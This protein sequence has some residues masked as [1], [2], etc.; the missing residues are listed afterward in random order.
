MFQASSKLRFSE[1]KAPHGFR[2]VGEEIRAV[3]EAKMKELGSDWV[4][5]KGVAAVG[6]FMSLEH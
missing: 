6:L 2:R 3:L 1:E 5:W 4:E